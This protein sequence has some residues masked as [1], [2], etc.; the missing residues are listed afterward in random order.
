MLN[1]ATKKDHQLRIDLVIDYILRN[2]S[3]ELSLQELSAVANYS[4]FHLQKVFK[5]MMGETPKQYIIRLRLENALHLLVIHSHKSVTEISIDCGFSSPS[6]FSR[7]IK[8]YFNVSPYQMRTF[9]IKE[10]IEIFKEKNPRFVAHLKELNSFDNQTS[11]LDI[12]VKK[13]ESVIGIYLNTQFDDTSTIQ[14]SFSELIQ[15]SSLNDIVIDNTKMYGILSPHKGSVYKTFVVIGE[16]QKLPKKFN[17]I[18]LRGGKYATFKVKGNQKETFK[19]AQY[20]NHTWLPANGYRIADVV[21]F[22]MFETNPSLKPYDELQR[23]FFI[24]IES[25]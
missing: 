2:L 24:P 8:N 1:K 6:V 22:E 4:T 5:E 15:L 19:A 13:I 14:E 18:K 20:L 11:K 23:E 10:K 25:R 16:N 7:A 17:S 9:S 21:G 3:K 12:E